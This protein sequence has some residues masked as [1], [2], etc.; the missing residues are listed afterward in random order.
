MSEVLTPTARSYTKE[1]G[2]VTNMHELKNGYYID[3]LYHLTFQ[4]KQQSSSDDF[5]YSQYTYAQQCS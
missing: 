5:G 4:S 1:N 3:S 2:F